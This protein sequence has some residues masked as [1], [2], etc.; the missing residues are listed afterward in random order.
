M[1]AYAHK[2][3]ETLTDISGY[4]FC[5]KSPSC[6]MERVKV[7]AADGKSAQKNGVG[8]YAQA[9]MRRWPDLP[10]EEDGR[11]NDANL[12]ENF[13]TR[14]YAYADWQR[15]LAEGMTPGRLTKFH[16][17]YKYLLL[18]HEPEGYRELGRL[19]AD[20]NRDNL[21][22]TLEQ[23][24]ARFMQALKKIPSRGRHHN[25]M[26]HMLGFFKRQLSDAHKQEMVE[27]MDKYRQ[28]LLPLLVPL[29]LLN[30]YLREFPHPFIAEQVYLDPF[31]EEL[32]LRYSA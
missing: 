8:I 10:V 22:D 27:V 25:V 11:L 4:I 31:P 7:Y 23:Y 16:T 20:C 18:A 24:R 1:Q 6:G 5:A 2:T 29:T 28:G 15:Q 19:V 17:R 21:A 14:I 12:R 3:A 26:Q 32:R 9:V 13:I 30:H